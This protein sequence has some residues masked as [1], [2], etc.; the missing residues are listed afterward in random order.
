[1]KTV[2]M[3]FLCLAPVSGRV[4]LLVLEGMT[5]RLMSAIPTP[6]LDAVLATGAFFPLQPEFPADTLP[7]LQEQR[8][9]ARSSIPILFKASPWDLSCR[10][11]NLH[12]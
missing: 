3:T 2:L 12:Y 10:N 4:V 11:I 6:A 1:M 5:E 7:T 8:Y 9:P